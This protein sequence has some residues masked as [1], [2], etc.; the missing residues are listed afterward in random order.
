MLGFPSGQRSQTQD[1]VLSASQVRILPL[2][3]NFY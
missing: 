2:A 1:L 3:F